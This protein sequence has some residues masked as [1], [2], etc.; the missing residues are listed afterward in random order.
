VPLKWEVG[1]GGS[2][3]HPSCPTSP[4]DVQPWSSE[5]VGDHWEGLALTRAHLHPVGGP[6]SFTSL[7]AHA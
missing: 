5:A 7:E 4:P 2:G 3:I 6:S 1:A